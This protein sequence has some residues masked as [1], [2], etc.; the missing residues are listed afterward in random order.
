MQETPAFCKFPL[1]VLVVIEVTL[2]VPVQWADCAVLPDVQHIT[3]EHLQLCN[4][5]L[6]QTIP[7][8]EDSVYPQL[9]FCCVIPVSFPQ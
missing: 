5:A 4:S 3:G 7:T 2:A 9:V 8:H 1:L 6:G